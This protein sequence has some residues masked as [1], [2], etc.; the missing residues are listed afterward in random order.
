M[1]ASASA[2]VA[3]TER[4]ITYTNAFAFRALASTL[5]ADV[6]PSQARLLHFRNSCFPRNSWTSALSFV[7]FKP[8]RRS[9]D[10]PGRW[11]APSCTVRPGCP[12]L[13]L[14]RS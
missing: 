3:R 10:C 9:S 4:S 13:W 1:S 12:R 5:V 2:T 8:T 6:V 14:T 7:S 11:R